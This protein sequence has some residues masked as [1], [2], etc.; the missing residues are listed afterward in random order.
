MLSKK[1]IVASTILATTIGFCVVK[2]NNTD[3]IK[4]IDKLYSVKTEHDYEKI[5]N[6]YIKT[7]CKTNVKNK[8]RVTPWIY[9]YCPVVEYTA[10]C[11][12]IQYVDNNGTTHYVASYTL[13]GFNGHQEQ[14]LDEWKIKGATVIGVSRE[15]LEKK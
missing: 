9:T 10:E 4:R 12:R 14:H 8:L 1:I 13:T 5:M 7:H 2:Y 15:V 3:V 11:P 6:G